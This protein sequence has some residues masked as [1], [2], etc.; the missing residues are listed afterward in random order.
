MILTMD[1]LCVT[2]EQKFLPTYTLVHITPK[3]FIGDIAP[4]KSPNETS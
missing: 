2:V 1:G 3:H 4:W